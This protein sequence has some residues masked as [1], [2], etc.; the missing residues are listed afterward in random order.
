MLRWGDTTN[1]PNLLAYC[2]SAVTADCRHSRAG[3][4]TRSGQAANGLEKDQDDR[5]RRPV[6]QQEQQQRAQQEQQR[7]AQY[8]RQLD[9][10]VRAAQLQATQLQA[11]KRMAQARAQEQ[12]GAQLRQQQERLRTTRDYSRDPYVTTPHT[13]RYVVS[14]TTRQTN[15]YGADCA[16]R[17]GEHWLPA[18]LQRRPG[19]SSGRQALVVP[20]C[21]RLSRCQLRL[22]WQLC[23]AVRLQLLLPAGFSPR[24]RRRLQ[25]SIAVRNVVERQPRRSWYRSSPRFWASRRSSEHGSTHDAPRRYQSP[26]G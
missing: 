18:G 4:G 13:Y 8:Q 11:Q 2:G 26:R 24:I 21:I 10:Q 22:Q 7:A 23:R 3:A 16:P 25:Q 17:G 15:Q 9:A 19:G 20:E 1:E 14:G 5:N 12:Y 6:S